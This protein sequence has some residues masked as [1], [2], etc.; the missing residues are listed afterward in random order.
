MIIPEPK[1][2]DNTEDKEKSMNSE[3]IKLEP[4][5]SDKAI[6]IYIQVRSAAS[7]L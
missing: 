6:N 7:K 5:H 2:S 4:K 3:E 1:H